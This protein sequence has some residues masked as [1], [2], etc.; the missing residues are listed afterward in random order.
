M[1]KYTRKTAFKGLLKLEDWTIT[2]TV[3][4]NGEN[5]LVPYN[6]LKALE[7]YNHCNISISITEDEPVEPK[8]NDDDHEEVED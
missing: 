5:M 6:F 3:K 7:E 4:V 2:E 1:A 8:E